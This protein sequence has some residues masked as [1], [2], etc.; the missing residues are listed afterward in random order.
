MKKSF[1]LTILCL[2]A[3][4]SANAQAVNN[5][6]VSPTG[7]AMW[8][9]SDEASSYEILLNG[10]TEDDNV[11]TSFFQHENLVD[12]EQYITT[13]IPVYSYG[14]GDA[15]DYVWTKA[16]CDN[17]AGASNLTAGIV[18]NVGF[19]SWTLPAIYKNEK[20]SE[21][22]WL[23]YDN[24][25]Y[26]ERVGLTLDGATFEPFK[27][28]IMLPASNMAQYAGQ[29]MTKVSFYDVEAFDG[30]VEIY[31]GGSTEPGTLLYSQE[32]SGN[33]SN[34]FK[35][36]TLN[37]AVEISGNKNVWLVFCNLNGNQPAA[38]CADQNNP[39]GRFIYHQDYGWLD[40]MYVSYPAYT[41]M[42][43]AYVEEQE[44][45]AMTEVI[46]AILYR[47]GELLSEL[48][49]DEHYIDTQ[50]K[51]GDEYTLRVVYS[52]EKDVLHYF[53][54]CPQTAKIES[55]VT[56][57]EN[58]DIVISIYPNPTKAYLNI[59]AENMTHI[60]IANTLGQ[61]VFD[62]AVDSDMEAIDMTQYNSGVFFVRITTEN[63]VV[64][65]RV[66]LER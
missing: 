17:Y 32:F 25:T 10:V 14:K 42:I 11:T 64:V 28:A 24:G 48:V 21:G 57:S 15:T 29:K 39:N 65:K 37:E 13:V 7:W 59:E 16:P 41:W 20:T 22:N 23:H 4:L 45:P 52:G 62:K 36:I 47:N 27:W 33:G 46:G 63:G 19:V 38:G 43:R 66:S 31:E 54:A 1:I 51:A 40:L 9:K 53:M 30:K 12:G 18:N 60:S 8:D 50:A 61:I 58:T 56:I 26:A 34:D 44:E 6:Y 49:T 35:E 55:G 2:F 5:L 3:I